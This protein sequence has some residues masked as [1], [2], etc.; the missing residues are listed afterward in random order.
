MQRRKSLSNQS[1]LC[2]FILAPHQVSGRSVLSETAPQSFH[3]SHILSYHVVMKNGFVPNLY[4]ANPLIRAG[5]IP[6]TMLLMLVV[7]QS[8]GDFFQKG[9]QG[10]GK[11]QAF[12]FGL[13]PAPMP[14]HGSWTQSVACVKSGSLIENTNPISFTGSCSAH[15]S[16]RCWLSLS[17]FDWSEMLLYLCLWFLTFS[18]FTSSQD[19]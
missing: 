3:G 14:F 8:I 11:C 7:F 17:T 15:V 16:R 19:R 13:L 6:S 2:N 4:P 1:L 12:I 18:P 10:D 9:R 5:T